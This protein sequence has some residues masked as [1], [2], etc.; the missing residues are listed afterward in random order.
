MVVR[1]HNTELGYELIATVPYAYYLHTI[2]E[3]EGT[4]SGTG[5][6]PFYFF[7][8]DHQIDPAPRDFAH[9]AAAAK[10]IPNIWIHKPKLNKEQWIPP[11]Y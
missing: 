3:L 6:E 2:G 8:H 1:S 10:E 4:V 9:T 5:S 11:P 7:S